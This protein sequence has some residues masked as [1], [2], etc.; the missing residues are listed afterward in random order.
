MMT[1][2]SFGGRDDY[3]FTKDS[4]IAMQE[5]TEAYTVQMFEDAYLFCYHRGRVTLQVRDMILARMLRRE[6]LN[7]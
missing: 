3:R 6:T 2:R 7:Y 1:D 4:L 5:A